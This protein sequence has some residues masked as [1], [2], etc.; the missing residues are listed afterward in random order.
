MGEDRLIVLVEGEIKD[1]RKSIGLWESRTVLNYYK[2][3]ALN[4]NK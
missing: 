2:F 4:C 1:F 3:A